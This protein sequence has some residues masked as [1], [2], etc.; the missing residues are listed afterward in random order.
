MMVAMLDCRCRYL[1]Q[2]RRNT[3]IGSVELVH[4]MIVIHWLLFSSTLLSNTFPVHRW[5]FPVWHQTLK[6]DTVGARHHDT[7]LASIIFSSPRLFWSYYCCL[8]KMPNTTVTTRPAFFFL[9]QNFKRKD[10]YCCGFIQIQL[11]GFI[12]IQS[13]SWFIHSIVED[14]SG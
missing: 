14:E 1:S 2:T 9:M 7:Q 8:Y 6:C 12:R 4:W 3:S 11:H 10:W 5:F 13:L